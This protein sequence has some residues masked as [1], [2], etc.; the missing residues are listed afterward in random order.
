MGVTTTIPTHDGLGFKQSG[1]MV[2]S[3]VYK[4]KTHGGNEGF[5][6]LHAS[7]GETLRAACGLY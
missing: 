2:V 4:H 7:R 3:V 5:T 6:Q 1:M